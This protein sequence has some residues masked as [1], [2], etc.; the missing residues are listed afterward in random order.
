[1]RR[2]SL[3]RLNKDAY[4][5]E[6]CS[7]DSIIHLVS[8][9]DGVRGQERDNLEGRETASIGETCKNGSDAVLRLRDQA[10]NSSDGLV[11]TTSQELEL[12]GALQNKEIYVRTPTSCV[13]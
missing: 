7:I 13:R 4:R 8:T 2:T 10:V 3:E 1:M 11:G 12:R 5:V 9:G 6:G